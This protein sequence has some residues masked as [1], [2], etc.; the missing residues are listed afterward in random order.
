M[1]SDSMPSTEGLSFPKN[2]RWVLLTVLALRLAQ[3]AAAKPFWHDGIYS[4]ALAKVPVSQ[5]WEAMTAGFEFNPPLTY[6]VT[7]SLEETIGQ[8]ELFTRMT[9]YGSGQ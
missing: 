5:A 2:G 1:E 4:L 7:R 9:L 3:V 8:G 6:L